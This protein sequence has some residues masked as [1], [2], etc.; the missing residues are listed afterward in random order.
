[1]KLSNKGPSSREIV[2]LIFFLLLLI[3]GMIIL[4]RSPRVSIPLGIG[5]VLSLILTP[6]L[7]FIL[8]TGLNRLSAITILFF[9]LFFFMVYPMT[10]IGPMIMNEAESLH[11]F[12]PKAEQFVEEN[13][14]YYRLKLLEKTGFDIKEQNS[15]DVITYV[16][17][18]ASIILTKIPTILASTLEVAFLAPFFLFFFLKD[19]RSF[20]MQVLRLIPNII[21]E[22]F[23]NLS[24][25]FNKQL[26]DYIVAKFV[27]ASILGSIIS[28]GLLV[29]GVKFAFLLGI[30][31]GIGN[32]IPYVGPIIG[33]LPAIV[34]LLAEYGLGSTFGAVM[35]LY[36]VANT[37]DVFLIFPILVSKI[38]DLHPVPV[39]ISVILGSHY[40]GIVGMIISIPLLAAIKLIFIEIYSE[41][42][43]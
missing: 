40:M 42:Y 43:S 11:A 33:V 24:F 18:S 9:G 29:M 6:L 26:S 39:V 22:R 28:I 13:Y 3:A 23:Y 37:V 20:K 16:T 4:V 35:I 27:E 21:F 2:R 12:L 38:V 30:I 10:K 8:K 14:H 25:K 7:P 34:L 15:S 1:M 32:I 36:L 5:Y 31:A 41:L 19:S 17:N